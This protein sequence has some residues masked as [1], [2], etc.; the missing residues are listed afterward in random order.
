MC[1]Y[2]H[3][4]V[5]MR[6]SER[7]LVIESIQVCDKKL[8]IRTSLSTHN[9]TKTETLAEVCENQEWRDTLTALHLY[10]VLRLYLCAVHVLCCFLSMV[11]I[12]VC[13]ACVVLLSFYGFDIANSICFV[14]LDERFGMQDMRLAI[15]WMWILTNW[16]WL[17]SLP[18]TIKLTL[19]PIPFFSLY[20]SRV[21]RSRTKKFNAET[22]KKENRTRALT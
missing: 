20:L 17:R 3:F 10:F 16:L 8:I 2:V 6:V 4:Y 14:F 11:L 18:S 12:F 5:C 1:I 21:S 9:K 22:I 19:T 15:S 13:C 7:V